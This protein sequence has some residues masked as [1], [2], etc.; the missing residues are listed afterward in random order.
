MQT[1][2]IKIDPRR[3]KLLD[4]NA[5]FMRFEVFQQ[6]VANVHSDEA[7]TSVPFAW[8]LQDDQT[9]ARQ[10]HE[11]GSP[12]Y[13]VLSGNHR[14]KAAISAGLTEIDVMI[15][16]DY[17]T[18]DRRVAIQLSHN[19][20]FGEDDPATLKTLFMSIQQPAMKLYAGLDDKTLKLLDDVTVGSLSEANLTFQTISMAFLPEEIEIV[21]EAW[22][23]AKRAAANAKGY[24]LVNMAAYDKVM[25][26]IEA[27]STSHNI[28][29]VATCMMLVLDIFAR[30]IDELAE[31]WYDTERQSAKKN[32][33]LVPISTVLGDDLIPA[34]T[35]ANLKRLTDRLIG[36]KAIDP[37]QR[38]Q[39]LDKLLT[40][41]TE[42]TEHVGA[43]HG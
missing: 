26:A 35:A 18:P 5:H 37:R 10:Y 27:T 8:H 15:T 43:E 13:E 3:I 40:E 36:E 39:V 42:L 9:K 30:H 34:A 11:D 28:K 6:L 14:V 38:W 23:A 31:G 19:A 22:D 1:R 17:L 21:N 16:D 20:I 2:V 7:L 12:I 24:W 25:N 4:L 32:A 33:K 29:N 41:K